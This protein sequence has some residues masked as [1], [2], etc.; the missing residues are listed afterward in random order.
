MSDIEGGPKTGVDTLTLQR[1]QLLFSFTLLCLTRHLRLLQLLLQ[2]LLRC[3]QGGEAC[4]SHCPL[5][6]LGCN[7]LER[8]HSLKARQASLQ[9]SHEYYVPHQMQR[10]GHHP[11]AATLHASITCNLLQM[12]AV[13]VKF[14]PP[15]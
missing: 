1:L 8:Q 9:G 10:Q 15:N 6:S 11:S 7:L 12:V 14:L 5:C 4:L 13:P 2:T 3:R